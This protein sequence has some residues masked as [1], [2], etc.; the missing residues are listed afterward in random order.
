MNGKIRFKTPDNIRFSLRYIRDHKKLLFFAGLCQ[1]I[2]CFLAVAAPIIGARIIR[3][4][5]NNEAWRV[6]YIAITLLV[7]QLLRNFFTVAGN[8]TYNRVYTKTLSTLEEDLVWNVLRVENYCIDEKG[9][10]LFIQRLTTDTG[11]IASGFNNLADMVTQI[12]NYVG[13]LIAMLIVDARIFLF[14]L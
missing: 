2:G 9:S 1:L 5:V 6:I 10:G 11:R 8:Q 12:I 3:A 13:I 4:Y 7:V 14:V